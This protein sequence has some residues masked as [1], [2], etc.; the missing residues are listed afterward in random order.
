V[1]LSERHVRPNGYG[2]WDITDADGDQVDSHHTTDAQ[3]RLW[4]RAIVRDAGGGIVKVI[5]RTGHVASEERV[6]PS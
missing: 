1:D 6:D 3:A 4:A 5:D 2:G